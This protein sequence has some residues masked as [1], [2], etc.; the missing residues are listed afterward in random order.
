M[1]KEESNVGS[2][3]HC[4]RTIFRDAVFNSDA[5]FMTRCPH[6]QKSVKVCVRKKVEI[7]LIPV[8]PV[9]PERKEGDK[10]GTKLVSILLLLFLL[11]PYMD[12]V[13]EIFERLV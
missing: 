3:P 8:V 7:I 12:L 10:T 1:D 5:T 9:K 11:P 13:P 4:T 6:C 2:C